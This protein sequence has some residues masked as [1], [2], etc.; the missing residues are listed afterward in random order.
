MFRNIWEFLTDKRQLSMRDRESG[1]VHW[2]LN[3]SPIGLWGSIITL[4]II[5]IVTLMLLMAH[6]SI[7]DIF[8]SY[9]T[10]NEAMHDK[11]TAAIMRLD[12]MEQEMEDMLEYNEAVT[13]ILNGSTPASQS[14]TLSDGTRYDKTTVE[15]SEAD[16]LLRADMEGE[17]GDY[18]LSNTKRPKIE[19]PIFAM[20]LNGHISRGFNSPQ[21]DYDIA[22]TPTSTDTTVMS[23]E[24]GTVIGL[25]NQSDGY[26]LVAIQH[27]GGYVSV[28]KHLSEVLV[29]R[30]QMVKGG[31]PIGSVGSI[32]EENTEHTAEL[33][34]ELWRDGVA[35]DPEPYIFGRGN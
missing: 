6:T 16:S 13:T 25:N 31:T 15:R 2:K 32:V 10:K 8:P 23:I 35:V 34:F 28:Y 3:L 12:A 30:G 27:A 17:G 21:S 1:E 19:A 18:A 33:V 7:L 26:A 9:R 14:T 22:L 4:V 5:V 11:M 29:R 24:S 20:P